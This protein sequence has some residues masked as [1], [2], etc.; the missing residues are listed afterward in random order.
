MNNKKKSPSPDRLMI[1]REVRDVLRVGRVTVL[2]LIWRRELR[3]FKAGRDWRIRRE[4]LER[5][6]QPQAATKR[7]TARFSNPLT[8]NPGAGVKYKK[9]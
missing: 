9:K 2:R 5:F 6:M 3:G 4:D 7:E 1:L 8:G